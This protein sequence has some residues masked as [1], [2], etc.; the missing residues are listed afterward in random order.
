M[1]EAAGS[2]GGGGET[3]TNTKE[4]CSRALDNNTGSV[5]SRAPAISFVGWWHRFEGGSGSLV[6][7]S[8]LRARVAVSSASG[9]RWLLDSG[10]RSTLFSMR[11]TVRRQHSEGAGSGRECRLERR[12][13]LHRASRVARARFAFCSTINKRGEKT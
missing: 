1:N 9:S 2:G 3:R 8:W 10:D 4:E 5:F 6:L 13:F 11:R 12:G 7:C